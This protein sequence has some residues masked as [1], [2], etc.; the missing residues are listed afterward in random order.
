MRL[1]P[2][3]MS[4]ERFLPQ[5]CDLSDFK[6]LEPIKIDSTRRDQNRRCSYHKDPGHTTEQYKSLHYLVE[7]LIKVKHLKQYVRTTNG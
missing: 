6:W 7:K 3:S 4:Y 2:L 5:I 1:T